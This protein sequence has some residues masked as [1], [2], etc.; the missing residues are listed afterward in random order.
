M[1]LPTHRVH[2]GAEYV[3]AL[4]RLADALERGNA[5]ILGWETSER[6]AVDE[7]VTSSVRVEFYGRESLVKPLEQPL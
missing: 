1:T 6:I 4:R 5:S 3:A 2:T 7:A